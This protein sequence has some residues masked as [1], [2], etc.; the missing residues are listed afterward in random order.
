MRAQQP[1]K[2]GRDLLI[3]ASPTQLQLYKSSPFF[4][5]KRVIQFG[6]AHFAFAELLLLGIVKDAVSILSGFSKE[7][8]SRRKIAPRKGFTLILEAYVQF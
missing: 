7:I 8:E 6:R 1:G 4:D 5:E 2:S 3:L